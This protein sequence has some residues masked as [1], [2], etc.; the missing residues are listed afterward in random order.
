M[1][2][3]KIT[4]ITKESGSSES[5]YTEISTLGFFEGRSRTIEFSTRQDMYDYIKN[6]G[7]AYVKDMAGNKLYLIAA[8]SRRGARYLKTNAGKAI[9]DILFTLPACNRHPGLRK[10]GS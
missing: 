1:N 7:K 4:C 6:G 3:R 5:Y 8:E 9:Q 2:E 10:H